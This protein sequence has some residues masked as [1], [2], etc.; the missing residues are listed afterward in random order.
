MSDD[1]FSGRKFTIPYDTTTDQQ[2]ASMA[3]AQIVTRTASPGQVI[4]VGDRVMAYGVTPQQAKMGDLDVKIRSYQQ[5]SNEAQEAVRRNIQWQ[6]GEQVGDADKVEK[7]FRG[8]LARLTGTVSSHGYHM[9]PE[10]Y[11]EVSTSRKGELPE[12]SVVPLKPKTVAT[13]ASAPAV[14]APATPAATTTTPAPKT[15]KTPKPKAEGKGKVKAA[16]KPEGT[17]PAPLSASVTESAAPTKRGKNIERPTQWHGQM[18]P[19]TKAEFLTAFQ[20]LAL[21][22]KSLRGSEEWEVSR[23]HESPHLS[24]STAKQD[25]TGHIER[26]ELEFEPRTNSFVHRYTAPGSDK[27]IETRLDSIDALHQHVTTPNESWGF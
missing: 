7:S 24:T 12:A 18:S 15:A 22:H 9:N 19:A 8:L 5:L 26:H 4:Q 21:K 16:P 17:A 1:M 11:P 25:W 10:L 20:N 6:Y 23:K 27:P 2:V 3:R 13:P 14:T